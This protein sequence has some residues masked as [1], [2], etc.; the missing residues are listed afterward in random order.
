M[1]CRRLTR[2]WPET[3]LRLDQAIRLTGAIGT[4]SFI[5]TVM[6]VAHDVCGADFVSVFCQGDQAAPLLIGTAC[7]LGQ[8]RAERASEGYKRH[9]DQD[10]NTAIL[11]GAHGEGDFLTSQNA[12]D[13]ASFPYRRDCYDLPGISGRV[14]WVRRRPEYGISVSLYS[15][16]EAGLFGGDARLT[17][18]A[19]MGLLLIA[20]ERHV[21]FSLRGRV[22]MA[23][24]VQTRLALTYP[25]LTRRECEVAALA[26]KGRTAK[27]SADL[28]GLSET[29]IIT[30]RKKA[31]KRMN[32]K[33]LRQLIGSF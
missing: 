25:D 13:I 1:D 6:A 8:S 11:S 10:L 7:H 33:S 31:Y 20:T 19:L 29:T 17:A 14:S 3:P 24:D 4:P 22:W 9:V 18:R 5:Q 23:D 28:L 12:K 30:H 21:A 2:P 27:E 16:V 26:I 32:V 15:S